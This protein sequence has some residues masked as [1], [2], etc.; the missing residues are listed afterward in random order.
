MI[1]TYIHTHKNQG[2]RW[3]R[4]K[5]RAETEGRRTVTTEFVTFLANAEGTERTVHRAGMS[6]LPGGR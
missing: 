4:L 5:V 2:Q 6:P 1:V 3:S